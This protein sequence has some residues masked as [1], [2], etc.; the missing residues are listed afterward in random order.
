MA[1]EKMTAKDAKYV[2]IG[3]APDVCYTGSK[4]K[5]GKKVP[6][7]ITHNMSTS[8]QCSDNVFVNGKPAF[9]HNLSYVDKVEG[10]EPGT[11]GG[12]ITGVNMEVSHSEKHSQSVFI[13]GKPVVRTGDK[14]HMNTKRP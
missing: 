12:V 2:L 8:E 7:Q 6:Y 4:K 9:L 10:D 11:G 1:D 13:N 5:K 3:L 14:V